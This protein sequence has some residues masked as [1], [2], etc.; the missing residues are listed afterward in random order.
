MIM[1]NKKKVLKDSR[2][3]YEYNIFT[4]NFYLVLKNQIKCQKMKYFVMESFY[5][6]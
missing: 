6:Y 5:A 3:S 2:P 1:F 4:H